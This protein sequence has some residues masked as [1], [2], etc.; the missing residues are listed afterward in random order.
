MQPG[1]SCKND[2]TP[3]GAHCD[4]L[5]PRLR[6]G[7]HAGTPVRCKSRTRL[8][9]GC[10]QG[11]RIGC[12][13]RHNRGITK[14]TTGQDIGGGVSTSR[15]KLEGILGGIAPRREE[16]LP[17]LHKVQEDLGCIAPEHIGPIAQHFN[18]SRAEVHGVVTFYHD[19][20]E[21]PCPGR[22]VAVCVAEACQSVGARQLVS[23]LESMTDCRLNGSSPDGRF[24]LE[25]VYCLGLCACGPALMIDGRLHG[26][27]SGQTLPALLDEDVR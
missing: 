7:G 26:R 25:P 5:R 2:A 17:L 27:V 23:E 22:R 10:L 13:L 20:R 16:L 8:T 9:Q 21:S 12:Q 18:L 4:E 24:T 11:W 19:F 6:Q 3:E 1:N 15:L 14:R